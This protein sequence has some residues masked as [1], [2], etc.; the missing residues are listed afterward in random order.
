MSI[1]TF[2]KKPSRIGVLIGLACAV[3]AWGIAQ[4]PPMRGLDR[5]SL[6][7]ANRN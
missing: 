5:L 2:L 7:P 4:W 3:A 6:G 1:L